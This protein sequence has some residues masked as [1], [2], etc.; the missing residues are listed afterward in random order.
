MGCAVWDGV[1]GEEGECVLARLNTM[2]VVLWIY[3]TGVYYCIDA[4]DAVVKAEDQR[5]N[6]LT[7]TTDRRL[8]ILTTTTDRR[9]NILTIL[10]TTV[11]YVCT[12]TRLSS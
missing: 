12:I 9:L 6:I 4:T 2:A 10:T 5:L 7:T 11:W 3:R 1:Y 8:N